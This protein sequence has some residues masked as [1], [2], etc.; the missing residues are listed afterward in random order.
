MLLL[1][2]QGNN[3]FAAVSSWC[4]TQAVLGAELWEGPRRSSDYRLPA[5]KSPYTRKST[6]VTGFVQE[7]SVIKIK[8]SHCSVKKK[9]KKVSHWITVYIWKE[10][11]KAH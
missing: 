8:V 11:H 2:L 7:L 1:L 3:L 9:K 6:D 4:C 10:I 5:E